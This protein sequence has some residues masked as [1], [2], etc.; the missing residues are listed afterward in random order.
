MTGRKGAT[1]TRAVDPEVLAVLNAGTAEAATLPENL[2]MDFAAVMTACF[3]AVDAAP[4]TAAADQGITRRMALAADLLAEA[5]GVEA[6]LAATRD[7]RSDIV[8]G[9][10][11]Y[12][13]GVAPDVD[14]ADRLDAIRPFADDH[15]FGVREWAWLGVRS[16]I[17]AEVE[18][19]ITVLAPWTASP[20]EFV[21]RFATEATR[22]RGVWCS[23][24]AALKAHPEKGLPL[25]EPL[26]AD[27][28]RY[29]RDS[30]ANW[31]NDAGKSQP[32]WLR[33]LADRWAADSPGPETQALLKRACRSLPKG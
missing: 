32:E 21:R 20:S 23:H 29:V 5:L 11:A 28:S 10:G 13:V 26:R 8:R 24:I 22:P 15:H 6:A 33:A 14:L 3:P 31:L 2:A 12:L 17:A 18:T 27:P 16:H 4:L 19:A 7:H 1:S 25:L 9:W 30:V